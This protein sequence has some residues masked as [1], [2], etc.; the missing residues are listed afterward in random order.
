MDKLDQELIKILDSKG[1]RQK[2]AMRKLLLYLATNSYPKNLFEARTAENVRRECGWVNEE[3]A[4]HN[5]DRL[6]DLLEEYYDAQPDKDKRRRLVINPGGKGARN[7]H[8]NWLVELVRGESSAVRRFWHPHF[9]DPKRLGIVSNA[10]LFFRSPKETHRVRVM[11]INDRHAFENHLA[12]PNAEPDLQGYLEC[13]HYVSLGDFQLSLALNQFFVSERQSVETRVVYASRD[14]DNPLNPTDRLDLQDCSN[15][16]AMGNRRVSWVVRELETRLR[17]NFTIPDGD[18]KRILNQMPRGESRLKEERWYVDQPDDDGR[19]HV[20]I[21]RK[22]YKGRTE[23][24]INVQNGP[25]LEA[26]ATILTDDDLLEPVLAEAGW[27]DGELPVYFEL[28]FAVP[29][30]KKELT[31]QDAAPKLLAHR[32]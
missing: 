5:C 7:K 24:L 11:S 22:V 25:A 8:T 3:T 4:W 10:P 12:Q 27:K 18:S 16:I 26:M 21:V 17:P 19:L 2:S 32:C 6:R 9:T 23:T 29:L 20:V 14:S 28:L 15:L 31:Q 30:S 1:F 13:F